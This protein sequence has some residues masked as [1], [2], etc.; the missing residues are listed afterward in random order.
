[1]G[2]AGWAMSLR[3]EKGGPRNCSRTAGFVNQD[4]DG[5]FGLPEGTAVGASA[6]EL[7]P[8]LRGLTTAS[9]VP[10]DGPVQVHFRLMDTARAS[11]ASRRGHGRYRRTE[12]D[13]CTQT[14]C[15][16]FIP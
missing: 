16:K 7:A 10:L 12:H 2:D 5:L 8:T 9:T 11:V 3:I 15:K 13:G 4:C 1:M 6:L 14:D